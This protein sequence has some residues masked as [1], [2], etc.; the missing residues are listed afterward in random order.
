MPTLLEDF[1]S[2]DRSR[3]LHATWE[4]IT[5]RDPEV[6]DPLLAALPRIRRSIEEVDLGGM[7]YSNYNNVL[8]ALDKLEN[9][10]KG[11]CWCVNYP[12]LL[13]YDPEKQQTVGSI[14]ILS[15]S[16]PGW[17]MTFVAECTVC[18][19]VFDIQQGDH[20]VMWWKWV[21]RGV[22][23]DKKRDKKR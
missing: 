17:S 21:P 9:Y 5:S 12:G 18:G 23:R 3:V 6:L 1:L 7:I 16:E 10:R 22:K 19:R 8:H 20:H 11:D 2:E 15:T 14:R 4:T 13:T